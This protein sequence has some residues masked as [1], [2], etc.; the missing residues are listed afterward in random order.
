M[1]TKGSNLIRC[2]CIMSLLLTE[3]NIS[4]FRNQ[5]SLLEWWVPRSPTVAQRTSRFLR[6]VVLSPYATISNG[7]AHRLQP[8][9]HASFE[10]IRIVAKSGRTGSPQ[11]SCAAGNHDLN[12]RNP[13]RCR[14]SLRGLGGNFGGES[15]RCL[16][17]HDFWAEGRHAPMCNRGN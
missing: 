14:R 7:M 15:T 10:P 5:I 13:P 4:E 8:Q 9:W 6:I 3:A 2:H 11:F 17:Q 12:C 1:S 16:N